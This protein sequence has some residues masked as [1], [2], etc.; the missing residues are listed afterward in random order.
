MKNENVFKSDLKRIEIEVITKQ[1][2]GKYMKF[3]R[4]L[5]AI[6]ITDMTQKQYIDY[7]TKQYADDKEQMQIIRIAC[8]NKFVNG[9]TDAEEM[10]KLINNSNDNEKY[11]QEALRL[12]DFNN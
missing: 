12:L 3:Y 5:N 9:L 4:P 1:N 2:N 6:V 10:I 11:K 8:I 7:W